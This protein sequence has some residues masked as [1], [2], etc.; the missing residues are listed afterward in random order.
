MVVRVVAGAARLCP[1]L[2][3]VF[4]LLSASPVKENFAHVYHGFVVTA[5]LCV[6]CVLHGHLSYCSSPSAVVLNCS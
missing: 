5:L 6:W 4:I 1:R 3:S 2:C